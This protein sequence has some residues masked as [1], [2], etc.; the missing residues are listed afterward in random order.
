MV[1]DLS[2]AHEF[3]T[4]DGNYVKDWADLSHRKLVKG[5]IGTM[6]IW[7]MRRR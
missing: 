6:V 3:R 2:A 4:V 7:N 5:H 1:E